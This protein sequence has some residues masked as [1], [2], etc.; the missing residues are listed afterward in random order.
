MIAVITE[1]T[2]K[3][4]KCDCANGC[5]APPP[6]EY[7]TSPPNVV[8]SSNGISISQGWRAIGAGTIPRAVAVFIR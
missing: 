2:A 8:S 4:M 5:I 7:S 1:N 6:A 3:R